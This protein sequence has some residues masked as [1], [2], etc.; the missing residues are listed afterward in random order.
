[1]KENDQVIA[2][3]RA[4]GDDGDTISI[5]SGGRGNMLAL[6]IDYA[7]GDEAHIVLD[8]VGVLSLALHLVNQIANLRTARVIGT[9]AD[10][11]PKVMANDFDDLLSHGDL[12]DAVRI[13]EH[14]PAKGTS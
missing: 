14:R 12:A 7:T 8:D 13:P 4:A 1:M 6:D 9:I 10:V 3:I 11:L 5:V 2:T